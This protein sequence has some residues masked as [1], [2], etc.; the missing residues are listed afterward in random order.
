MGFVTLDDR[1]GRV[2]VVLNSDI[3]EQVGSFLGKDTVLIV[4]GDL[5]VDE[6]N[7][8]YAIRAREVYDLAA[9]RAR[10]ARRLIINITHDAL[11]D[12]ALDEL[13]KTL[14]A[15]R[16]GRT[17]VCF[18]YVNGVASARIRAGNDWLIDPACELLDDL[19]RLAGDGAVELQY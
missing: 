17:P 4:D 10:F 12:S 7:G 16:P 5:A 19:H 2:D 13:L 3:L 1:S 14:S 9:A 15:H 11:R 18:E 6:F 8:G